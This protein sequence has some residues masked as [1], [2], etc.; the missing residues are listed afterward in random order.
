MFIEVGHRD[1]SAFPGKQNGHGTADAGIT[2]GN[3]RNLVL[4]FAGPDVKRSVI[5]GGRIKFGFRTWLALVLAVLASALIW[6]FD[7]SLTRLIQLYVVGVFTAFTLSQ[8]G[9]VRRWH[10]LRGEGWRRSMIINGTGAITTGTVLVIVAV[11]KFTHGA[12]IVIAA[13]PVIVAFFLSV[14]RH[15]EAV[16]A[17]LRA[18]RAPPRFEAENTFVVLVTDL[19]LATSEA[20]TYLRAI[21]PERVIPLYVG[22]REAFEETSRGW[23]TLAPRLGTIEELPVENG[24]VTRALRRYLH[25]LP[26]HDD[27]FITVVVPETLSSHSMLQ[28][29]RTRATLF[30]KTALLFEPGIVITNCPLLPEGRAAA[31]TF[32]AHPVEP[33]RS[34]V[35]VPLSAVHDATVR[36]VAY[37]KSLRPTLIEGL[38]FA[39]DPEEVDPILEDW[40]GWRLD[41]PLTVV[42]APF[43]DVKGPLLGEIRRH[44]AHPSTLVTVVLPEFI[45]RR[46]WEHLLHNQTGLYIK[47]FLLFEPQVVVTSVPYR[48]EPPRAP[49]AR[50]GLP[51]RRSLAAGA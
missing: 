28:F 6:L 44:T 12:W 41:V 38:F 43:R 8:S 9:M 40:A 3:E 36:A 30:L 23:A 22:P 32:A 50:A 11:T 15:Y 35:L 13:M 19:G 18:R 4:K 25:M 51:D 24:S 47:R 31:A 26:R 39:S 21:R 29:L 16:G 42:D 5:K 48:L 46:W 33:E 14:H 10:R 49:N 2:A 20:V 7:A 45:V 37:A 27:E 34:V 1:V 17:M